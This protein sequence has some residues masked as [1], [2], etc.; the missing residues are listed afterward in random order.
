MWLRSVGA[1][2]QNRSV[3]VPWESGRMHG[4]AIGVGKGAHGC[5]AGQEGCL[6]VHK[7]YHLG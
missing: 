3:K 5:G 6:T 2:S 1:K 4:N 7:K